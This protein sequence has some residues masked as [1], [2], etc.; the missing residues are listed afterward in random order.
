VPQFVNELP[1]ALDPSFIF[2]E[3]DTDL[4]E[5]GIYQTWQNVLG[6][7]FNDTR[8]YGYGN[9]ADLTNQGPTW[10]GRTFN[11]RANHVTR[12]TWINNL[13]D[14]EGNELSHFLPIDPTVMWADPLGLG[15][16]A[17]VPVQGPVPT[18]VHV[19]GVVTDEHSDGGA[20]SWFTPGYKHK[21]PHFGSATSVYPNEQEAGNPWYH[22]HALGITRLNVYAGLAGFWLLRDDRD[23]G[24]ATNPLG[25]PAS[26]YEVPFVIQD[27]RFDTSHQLLFPS[28]PPTDQSPAVSILPDFFGRIICVNGK[29]W[30]SLEVERRVYRFRVINGCDSRILA[31]Q[32][33][34]GA[35]V[36]IGV[37]AGFLNTAVTFAPG[38]P[39]VLS[40]G[41]RADILI[42]FKQW[43]L[44]STVLLTNTRNWEDGTA[45]IPSL[46]GSVLQ[47]RIAKPLSAV[48]DTAIRASYRDAPFSIQITPLQVRSVGLFE[49]TD[50]FGRRK[51][52]LGKKDALYAY[53]DPITEVVVAGSSEI[54]DI[55]NFGGMVHPIHLHV[56]GFVVVG[57]YPTSG[58]PADLVAPQPNELGPKD[59]V[60]A[61]PT[62]VTR[63]HPHFLNYTGIFTWHCHILSHEDYDMMR[64]YR[65]VSPDDIAEALIPTLPPTVTP[66][67]PPVN[68]PVLITQIGVH[69]VPNYTRISPGMTVRWFFTEPLGHTLAQVPSATSRTPLKYSW[70]DSPQNFFRGRY[71]PDTFDVTFTDPGFYYYICQPHIHLNMRG[72]I[73]VVADTPTP[74]PT[75]R[76]NVQATA[77][78][79]PSHSPFRSYTA[80]PTPSEIAPSPLPDYNATT[81]DLPSLAPT[82]TDLPTHPPS[83]AP[84]PTD[85]PTHPPS[86][87]P[88]P[89]DLPTHPPSMVPTPTVLSTT[90]LLPSLTTTLSPAP[91]HTS[92][93]INTTPLPSSV[94][95][96]NI[97]IPTTTHYWNTPTAPAPTVKPSV[98]SAVTARPSPTL[99]VVGNTY[100]VSANQR[101]YSL[102]TNQKNPL[103]LNCSRGGVITRFNRALYGTLRTTCRYRNETQ[104]IDFLTRS[105]RNRKSFILFVTPQNLRL[106]MA[107]LPCGPIRALSIQ[108]ECTI[109]SPSV[110]QPKGR[111]AV[112]RGK[113]PQ[114]WQNQ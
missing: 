73:E 109:K 71:D 65:I 30:P 8:I 82:P 39:I 89:T 54:W 28:D 22:D 44:G 86:I 50:D 97:A 72:T 107:L 81:T 64:P 33:A 85:L 111:A 60:M 94:A 17:P 69:F 66:G 93:L 56:T 29:A 24:L 95:P 15:S 99:L 41:E 7:N 43:D 67:P 91:L 62:T 112:P 105:Y 34:E 70:D 51:F 32:L 31:L 110:I 52:E 57:R 96:T 79:L 4:Y 83:L 80:I 38:Q 18:V 20:M 77:T 55:W 48:P 102:R 37:D 59:T 58:T 78:R 103:V 26:P 46:D 100:L 35:M 3:S 19:H 42:D 5:I 74:V 27:R 92:P 114:Q 87:A 11:L 104:I 45:T 47:F 49:S 21:G 90:M 14:E 10:P 68:A 12:V 76:R 113:A 61:L 2:T 108:A 23:T 98:T 1:H 13:V 53:E 75:R 88:T 25:L 63:I 106:N 84:T 9:A 36:Q 6:P 16:G 101:D 40:P